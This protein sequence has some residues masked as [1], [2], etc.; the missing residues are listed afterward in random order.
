[1]VPPGNNFIPDVIFD[2]DGDMK[3]DYMISVST[4]EG[5]AQYDTA[6]ATTTSAT[7]GKVVDEEPIDPHMSPTP[8]RSCSP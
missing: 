5:N 7:T 3:A 1:M 8:T 4:T 6:W 2:V